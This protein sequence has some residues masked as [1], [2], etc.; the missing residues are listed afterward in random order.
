MPFEEAIKITPT[1]PFEKILTEYKVK[2]LH[3]KGQFDCQDGGT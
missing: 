3:I 1:K 2:L